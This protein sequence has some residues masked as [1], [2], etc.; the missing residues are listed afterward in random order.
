MS[1]SAKPVISFPL[2]RVNFV[3]TFTILVSADHP[4]PGVNF[5]GYLLRR[6]VVSGSLGTYEFF[7]AGT[8]LWQAGTITNTVTAFAPL[9]TLSIGGF[10]F[11]SG[12]RYQMDIQLRDTAAVMSPVSDAV[13]AVPVASGTPV[14]T[15]PAAAIS[16]SRPKI[17]WVF[18]PGATGAKQVY[19]RV[20]IHEDTVGNIYWDSVYRYD[21]S[22]ISIV[23]EKDLRSGHNY[24]FGLVIVDENGI[25]VAS[26]P[27]SAGPY[28]C[29][30]NLP[31]AP[32]VTITPEP[33]LGT[34]FIDATSAFNLLTIDTAD[35]IASLGDWQ[36]IKNADGTLDTTVFLLGTG[37]LRI[38]A[39][40]KSYGFLD[41]ES[42]TF[43]N[44]DTLYA[45]YAAEIASMEP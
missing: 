24:Y 40:G 10:G 4:D 29:T 11:T 41:T 36:D 33:A 28:L 22:R 21:P 20:L 35:M 3:P 5:N 2:D 16:A 31:A 44:E 15:Q 38:T 17:A 34:M 32:S 1:S 6:R 23:S 26:N 39:A 30:L 43:A 13:I 8:N 7:N 37:S 42:G 25:A 45:D 14:V 9:T 12:T 18:T 27:A 19:W